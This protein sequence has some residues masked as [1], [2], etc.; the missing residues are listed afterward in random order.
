MRRI[1]HSH[2][3]N[4]AGH[5]PKGVVFN[6]SRLF[7]RCDLSRLAEG[8][9]RPEKPFLTT[10]CDNFDGKVATRKRP[11]SLGPR[12]KQWAENTSQLLF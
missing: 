3:R 10:V 5:Y 8:F 12:L 11:K 1:I 7:W 6:E 4:L 9:V 2:L